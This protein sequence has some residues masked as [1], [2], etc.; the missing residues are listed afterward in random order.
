MP[1][2]LVTGLDVSRAVTAAMEM[3]PVVAEFR[4][5][6]PGALSG[7]SRLVVAAAVDVP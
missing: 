5:C 6:P 3:A 2:T 1:L 4:R 7:T